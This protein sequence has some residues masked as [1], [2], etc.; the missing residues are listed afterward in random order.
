MQNAKAK[1]TYNVTYTANKVFVEG[2]RDLQYYNKQRC[3]DGDII[4]YIARKVRGRK[5]HFIQ[6]QNY[7]AIQV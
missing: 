1:K 2:W 7:T 5:Q 6:V 4:T 3:V